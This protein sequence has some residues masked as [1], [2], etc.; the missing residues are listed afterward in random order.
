MSTQSN[1]NNI[2][3]NMDD[4]ATDELILSEIR[5]LRDDLND[6]ARRS[7]ERLATLETGMY[8]LRGNG[9]PGR[10]TKMEDAVRDLNQ[11]TARALGMAAAIST[12]VSLVGWYIVNIWKH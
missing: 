3:G 12:G 4:R 2:R 8:D 10:M 7:G 9:Q 6:Y 1:H 5:A 11:L